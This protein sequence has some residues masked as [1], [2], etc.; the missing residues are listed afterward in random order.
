MN[1]HYYWIH[2]SRDGFRKEIAVLRNVVLERLLPTFAQVDQESEAAAEAAWKQLNA[3]ADDELEAGE[4]AE[5]AGVAHYVAMENARQGLLN[6]F[7][8]AL[9]HLVEQQQITVLRQELFLRDETLTYKML[10]ATEFVKRLAAAEIKV[11]E[12]TSWQK[13][14]E[15]RNVA[16]A[17]K[18]AEGSSAEW[19]RRN[20]PQI[21]TAPFLRGDPFFQRPSRWLFQP[22]TGQDLYVTKD[23]LE[24]YF[25][26]AD[27]FWQEFEKAL[28]SK[29]QTE[30]T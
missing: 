3:T 7:A 6:L 13:L 30:T 5:E 10:S 22:L 25:C 27:D 21:F 17:V 15:L 24:Q 9:H 12:S 29:L 18:H 23:D 28:V 1:N 8:V 14:E 20:R 19:L 16:N 11:A 2:R 4:A 26:S